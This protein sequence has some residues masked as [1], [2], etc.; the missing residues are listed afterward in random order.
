MAV[1]WWIGFL[2]MLL[3]FAAEYKLLR[4]LDK[5]TGGL[6]K[7]FSLF[8]LA[9]VVGISAG[10]LTIFLGFLN[11]PPTHEF[12]NFVPALFALTMVIFDFATYSL[13]Y[14]F[15]DLKKRLKEGS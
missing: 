4:L 14:F 8:L 3:A 6:G 13:E 7:G 9:G 15:R 1:Y 2:A 12:W 11:V 10:G 5:V